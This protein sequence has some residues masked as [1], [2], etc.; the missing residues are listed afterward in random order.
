MANASSKSKGASPVPIA[1]PGAAAKK[2]PPKIS[3]LYWRAIQ[4]LLVALG[5]QTLTSLSPSLI[6]TFYSQG[7]YLFVPR[8]LAKLHRLASFSLAEIFLGLLVAW[9]LVLGIWSILQGFLGKGGVF[10]SIQQL[11]LQLVWVASVLF[12]LF[13]VMWGFN[14][15]RQPMMETL[16]SELRY[17]LTQDLEAIGTRIVNGINENHAA[18]PSSPASNPRLAPADTVRILSQLIEASFQTTESIGPA[19]LGEYPLPK[20]LAAE[21]LMSLLGIR[22]FYFPFTGEVS[23]NPAVPIAELPFAIARAKAYQRGYA[24]EDEARFVAF[25][26]CTT[27]SDPIV[28]YSGFLHA[29]EV[30]ETLENSRIGSFR[31][32]LAEGP[33]ADLKLLEDYWGAT[34]HYYPSRLTEMLFDFHLRVNRESRGIASQRQEVPLIVTSMLPST[35]S[36][37]KTAGETVGD[38]VSDTP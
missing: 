15:Q 38:E 29:V 22:A 13:K 32:Q 7:L 4:W 26:V 6:E 17:P 21:S 8:G 16:S 2:A 12:I 27:A 19:A 18:L 36:G 30:L 33:R 1:L 35:A 11:V 23:Y 20:P 5:I 25:L 9:F 14:Y 37:A 24:R 10:R 28:R 31:P 34:L 3:K